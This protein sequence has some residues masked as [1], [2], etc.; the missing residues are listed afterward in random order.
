V[1]VVFLDID[2]VL[3]SHAFV[4]SIPQAERPSIIGLDREAIRRLNRLVH[5]TGASV[6]VSSTWRLNRNRQQLQRVLDEHGFQGRVIGRT[7]RWIAGRPVAG[8][9]RGFEIQAWLDA[10]ADYGI[11]VD[12]FVILDDDSDMGH[13]ADRL[14]KTTFAEGLRDEH[15]DTAI[16][17]LRA[18]MPVIVLAGTGAP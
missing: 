7:P 8:D 10:A 1:K 13:L 4:E 12:T 2:G 11:D 3:N 14:V 5:Q 9:A 15:V 6:V 16:A 17:M 18:P